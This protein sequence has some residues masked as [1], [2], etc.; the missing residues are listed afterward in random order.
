[1]GS[2]LRILRKLIDVACLEKS[3][4]LQQSSHKLTIKDDF[5]IFSQAFKQ[6]VIDKTDQN[7]HHILYEALHAYFDANLQEYYDMV[8]PKKT[9]KK[10]SPERIRKQS[11]TINSKVSVLRSL[12]SNREVKNIL[13]IGPR[14]NKSTLIEEACQKEGR[15]YLTIYPQAS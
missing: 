13:V 2:F 7:I 10:T 3:K 11:V 6:E 9:A 4:M 1:M 5:F 8:L 12:M 15:S 14:T